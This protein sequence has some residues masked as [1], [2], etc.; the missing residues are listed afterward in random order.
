[1]SSSAK[2]AFSAGGAG[3]SKHYKVNVNLNTAGGNRK[4]GLASTVGKEHWE[5]NAIQTSAVGTQAGR[6][7]I[8]FMNQLGGVGRGMS[9]FTI[10]NISQARGVHRQPS[11]VFSMKR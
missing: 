1:M 7:T 3:S 8:F 6:S 11:Y 2:T 10:P 5:T 4:Q 9:Q